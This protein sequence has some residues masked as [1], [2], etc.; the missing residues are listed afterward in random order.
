MAGWF[1]S[2]AIGDR[3]VL[4]AVTLLAAGLGLMYLART[5]YRVERRRPTVD[6]E[7]ISK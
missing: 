6:A 2:F 1:L 3:W 4:R 5:V 7:E